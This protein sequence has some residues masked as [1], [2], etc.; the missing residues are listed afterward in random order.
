M[1]TRQAGAVLRHLNSA[2]APSHPTGEG[3]GELLERF[4]LFVTPMVWGVCRASR[5]HHDAEDALQATF[6]VLSRRA[7]SVCRETVAN[8][9]LR[10]PSDR[11]QGKADAS[12][13]NGRERQESSCPN[14]PLPK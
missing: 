14:R 13:R 8:W 5:N 10:G 9:L 1:T 12:R 4:V 6:I 11:S 2:E 3:D 7:A